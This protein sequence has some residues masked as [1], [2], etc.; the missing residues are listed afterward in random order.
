MKH[1]KEMK[2]LKPNF[3]K[4]GEP[5]TV[6]NHRGKMKAPT[7]QELRDRIETLEIR[8]AAHLELYL[9]ARQAHKKAL[10]EGLYAKWA[11]YALL[12]TLLIIVTWEIVL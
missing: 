3:M 2:A 10:K 5:Y 8:A 11:A 9:E 6:T 1:I 7:K 12:V 4:G